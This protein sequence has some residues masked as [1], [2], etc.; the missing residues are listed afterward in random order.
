M[1]R[2]R[3]GLRQG[4]VS[5][6]ENVRTPI[7]TAAKARIQRDLPAPEAR[8]RLARLATTTS[9]VGHLVLEDVRSDVTRSTP[10]DAA[11]LDTV[12]DSLTSLTSALHAE[13]DRRRFRAEDSL[14]RDFADGPG[15]PPT[16]PDLDPWAGDRLDVLAASAERGLRSLRGTSLAAHRPARR[17]LLIRGDGTVAFVDWPW[18]RTGAAWLDDAPAAGERERLRRSRDEPLVDRNLGD[19]PAESVTAVL[20]RRRRVTSWISARKRRGGRECGRSSGIRRHHTGVAQA[21]DALIPQRVPG[22][23]ATMA[24]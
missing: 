2:G 22:Y 24:P 16:A 15:S 18:A 11:E 8:T 12:L 23:G 13:P 17:Q 9:R 6:A 14:A 7:S 4:W 20:G 5:A 19:V 21:A 3:S 10:W 1:R